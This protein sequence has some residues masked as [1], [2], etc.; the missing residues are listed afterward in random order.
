MLVL[1]QSSRTAGADGKKM[2]IS[3]GAYGGEQQATHILGV[4]RK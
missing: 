2:T 3:S 4:R 1:H